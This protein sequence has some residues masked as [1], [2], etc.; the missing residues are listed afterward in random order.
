M[1]GIKGGHEFQ[2]RCVQRLSEVLAKHDQVNRNFRHFTNGLD[3]FV[4]TVIV[5]GRA[6]EIGVYA[7]S[8]TMWEDDKLFECYMPEEFTSESAL[9]EGFAT[10][11]DRYLSGG[12]WEG[13]DEKGL[14]DLI[15]EKVKALFRR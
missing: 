12:P 13:P 9:I 1:A 6:H 15:K 7:D 2:L 4:A 11:L 14:L 3:R 5:D 10:R 8:V